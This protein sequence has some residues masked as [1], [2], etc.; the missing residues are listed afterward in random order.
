MSKVRQ[1][2]DAAIYHLKIL[3]NKEIES[4]K[5]QIKSLQHKVRHHKEKI[6][7]LRLNPQID[8][9]LSQIDNLNDQIENYKDFIAESL[10]IPNPIIKSYNSPGPKPNPFEKMSKTQN[11]FN[12]EDLSYCETCEFLKYE[13]KTKNESI[14]ELSFKYETSLLHKEKAEIELEKIK[15]EAQ[16]SKF[17]SDS[18]EKSYLESEKALKNE[19]KYLIGKLLKAKSKLHIGDE[20]NDSFKK[21]P[22]LSS[23]RSRSINRSKLSPGPSPQKYTISPN[24]TPEISRSDSPFYPDVNILRR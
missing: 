22:N 14:E 11:F 2:A 24:V 16:E 18:I 1:E 12:R 19:I 5:S 23:F 8:G 3:F 7:K 9:Y 4:L 6:E 21:D 13:I 15:I 17:H 10:S 20:I